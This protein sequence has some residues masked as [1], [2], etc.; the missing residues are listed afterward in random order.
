MCGGGGGDDGSKELR[1]QEAERQAQI[2]AG[3]KNV[4]NAFSTFNDD[5]YGQIEQ[6][7]NDYYAPQL[8]QQYD[9]ARKTIILKAPGGT[10]NSG[11]AKRMAELEQQYQQELG[12]IRGRA[13]DASRSRRAEVEQN[14]SNLLS[15]VNTGLKAASA[16]SLAAEQAKYLSQP[17]A[18]S[19]LADIFAQAT[20]DVANAQAAA[21]NGYKPV[22][23]LI[24]NSRKNDALN[25]VS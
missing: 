15:Q 8:Q 25:T 21:S 22:T 9:D 5:Y 18:F 12:S 2:A 24:F 10:A 13:L 6:S 20:A 23:P 19:P 4:D 3:T 14:R 1:R 16:A 7:Y 11:F 17:G